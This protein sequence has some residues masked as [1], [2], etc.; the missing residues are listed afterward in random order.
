MKQ[1]HRSCEPFKLLNVLDIQTCP[2]AFRA[3]FFCGEISQTGQRG[4]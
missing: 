2:F 4:S 1:F 3:L